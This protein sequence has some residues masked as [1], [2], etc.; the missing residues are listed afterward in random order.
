MNPIFRIKLLSDLYILSKK[1]AKLHQ[2]HEKVQGL[3]IKGSN[4]GKK[5]DNS[6]L[7]HPSSDLKAESNEMLQLFN[8][9]LALTLMA[10]CKFSNS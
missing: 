4:I 7:I 2:S 10:G 3:K 5:I 1:S 8:F 6:F 9:Y